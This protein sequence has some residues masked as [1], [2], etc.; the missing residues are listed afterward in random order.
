[1]P[2]EA[3]DLQEVAITVDKIK[4]AASNMTHGAVGQNHIK[5]V[6]IV[7]RVPSSNRPAS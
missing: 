2:S 1:M 4:L 6:Q 5:W 3:P 7:A